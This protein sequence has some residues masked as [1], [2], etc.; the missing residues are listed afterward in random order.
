M[1]IDI[2]PQE[3]PNFMLW[4][5]PVYFD[6]KTYPGAVVLQFDND[7]VMTIPMKVFEVL[8]FSVP[9]QTIR[10]A[11]GDP[12][13]E[14]T[15]TTVFKVAAEMVKRQELGQHIKMQPRDVKQ[16]LLNGGMAFEDR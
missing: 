11:K 8:Q 13:A 5:K 7:V 3:N 14:S 12:N 2:T 6:F 1:N 4:G 10:I 16:K 15:K 9:D